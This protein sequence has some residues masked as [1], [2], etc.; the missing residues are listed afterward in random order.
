[1]YDR[2]RAKSKTQTVSRILLHSKAITLLRAYIRMGYGYIYKA[3]VAERGSERTSVGI[4][5]RAIR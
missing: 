1:M 4:L 2:A 5:G 3:L